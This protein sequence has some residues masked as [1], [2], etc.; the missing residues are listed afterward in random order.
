MEFLK[1]LFVNIGLW[2]SGWLT[3]FMPAWGVEV[4]TG[5]LGAIILVFIGLFAVLI[6]TWG[7]RKVIG[8]M[9]DRIGPNRWGP[10]GLFQPIADGIKM[11]TKEDIIPTGAD[12]WVH[13]VAPI[14]V[15][16]PAVLIYAVIPFGDGLR[17]ADLNIGILY[18]VALST[19][20]TISILMA[21]W[22]SNNKYSL[23][24]AFR[25][26][27]QLIT[28]EI[29]LVLSIITVVLLTGSMSMVEIVEN[30]TVPYMVSMPLVFLVF[31]VAASAELYRAPFDMIEADSELIA[32]YFTEYS[33]M[34]FVMFFMAEYINLLAMSGVIVTLFMGGWRFF[35]L[36]EILPFLN[37]F[38]FFAKCAFVI[39]L[40]WW[41]RATFPRIRV[42]HMLGMAWKALVPIA[43]VNLLLTGLVDKLVEGTLLTSGVL[44]IVNIIEMVILLAILDKVGG[45]TR[46]KTME[47]VAAQQG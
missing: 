11:L 41:T 25:A 23:L 19:I 2:F 12:R 46:A 15:I 7:E 20:G 44:L 10:Y 17:G 5:F 33:G 9:Q 13:L 8:R 6:L 38:I 35:G 4:V 22:S 36:E 16:I 45:K 21:G 29:P 3:G 47:R 40:F 42:D 30:Q 31:M 34:K 14:L 43:L 18:I 24:G 32:G 27:A 1:D 26:V 39:F 28:Y 37:P